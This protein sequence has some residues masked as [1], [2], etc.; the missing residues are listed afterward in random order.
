[1]AR[2]IYDRLISFWTHYVIHWG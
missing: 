1:M 2:S